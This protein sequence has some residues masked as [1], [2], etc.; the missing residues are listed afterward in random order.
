MSLVETAIA[1]L[2]QAKP[3]AAATDNV[4]RGPMPVAAATD[5]VQRGP[6][7]VAAATDN[8]QRGPVPVPRATDKVQRG[9]VPADENPQPSGDV[10]SGPAVEIDLQGLRSAG[11][12]PEEDRKRQFADHYRQ[13][14][15]PIID[16]AL[17]G[18]TPGGMDPRLIMVTSALP[19]DGKTFTSVN[20]ALSIARERDISVL[21]VDA[22]VLKPHVSK[23]FSITTQA[24]LTDLLLDETRRV[25]SL[26][27]PTNIR[28]LSLLPAGRPAEGGAELFASQRMRQLLAN[29]LASHPRRLVLLDSPPLLLTSE[30][31]ALVP[32]VGQVVLVVRAGQTPLSAV[33]DAIGLFSKEQAGLVLNHSESAYSESYYGYYGNY[34]DRTSGADR[35]GPAPKR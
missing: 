32:V 27:L 7:P 6:V 33:R 28:G 20:L 22:D 34:G 8:V 14:K 19:G 3:V 16:K 10:A 23:I 24:G 17:A 13:I 18:A 5:N 2:R 9:P 12:L 21:L 26:V 29:L 25:E 30:S 31:R 4:Q 1:R 15:R 11:Y 35:E